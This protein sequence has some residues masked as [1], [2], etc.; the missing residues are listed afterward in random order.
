MTQIEEEIVE[1][2]GNNAADM[3]TYT[4]E[5]TNRLLQLFFSG[6][7]ASPFA[8]GLEA[9]V[10]FFCP[11]GLVETRWTKDTQIRRTCPTQGQS[12]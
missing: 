4:I 10:H 8:A 11:A 3:E 5:R 7:P 1:P 2:V 9:L 6:E 12:C